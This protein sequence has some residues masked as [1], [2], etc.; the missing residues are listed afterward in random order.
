MDNIFERYQFEIDNVVKT[1]KKQKA[2]IVLLQFPDGLKPAATQIADEIEKKSGCTC[3]IWLGTC[4]GACDLPNIDK[5]KDI[6][7]LVQ[8]GHM[9]WDYGKKKE[10]KI[11]K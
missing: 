6:D 1:I 7:L 8:F 2:K 5:I 3:L 9:S 11:V 4:F 10:I